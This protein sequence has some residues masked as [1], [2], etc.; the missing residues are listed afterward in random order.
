[1]QK[2]LVPDDDHVVDC[3]KYQHVAPQ[4]PA[5]AMAFGICEMEPKRYKK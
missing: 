1:M 4:W 3:M 2:S 5:G